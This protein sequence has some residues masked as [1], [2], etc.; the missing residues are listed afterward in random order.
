[1]RGWSISTHTE[2]S[3]EEA[4]YILSQAVSAYFVTAALTSLATTADFTAVNTFFLSSMYL[5]QAL[6]SSG[7][8]H[9]NN[10]QIQAL[11]ASWNLKTVPSL[12]DG[13]C[14]FRS[15]AFGL[16]HQ[17]QQGDDAIKQ[18]MISL[19]IP[20]EYLND[21]E[22]IQR[23]LRTKM[24]EEWEKNIDHYQGY[25]TQD[26]GTV[27]QQYLQDGEFAGDGGDLMVLTLAN[28]LSMPIT[29]FT[30]VQI[31]LYFV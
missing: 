16:I 14:L 27:T 19:G 17:M 20:E 21:I 9:F 8:T 1:M 10:E 11:L 4:I 25:I 13:N 26:L 2:L 29:V 7:N 3:E 28:V 30:P 18:H 15:V 12:G 24:V 23:L 31:C 6:T 22:Y 5:T